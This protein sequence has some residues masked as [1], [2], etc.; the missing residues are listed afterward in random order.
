MKKTEAEI[1]LEM[2][3]YICIAFVIVGMCSGFL[4]LGIGLLFLHFGQAVGLGM[5]SMIVGP[6]LHRKLYGKQ[7]AI[8]LRA[9]IEQ[10]AAR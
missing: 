2:K 1:Q 6:V 9:L 7:I 10:D 5:L 4:G 8:R 3:A